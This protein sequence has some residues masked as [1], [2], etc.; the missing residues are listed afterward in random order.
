[1]EC[2]S[3]FS[4]KNNNKQIEMT[5]N[6]VIK[7]VENEREL[8]DAQ[9]VRRKVFQEEQEINTKL[10]FDGKDNEAEHIIVYSN[11]L[12]IGTAR[13]RYLDGTKKLAKIE[14]V[15]VI[16]EY[17][18]SGLGK[19]IMDYL[20]KYLEEKGVEEFKLESQEH[21]KGFY[22]KLGYKQNG[23][24]FEEVGIPHIEMRMR[25]RLK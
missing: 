5:E 8:K 19:K 4:D 21:A 23:D 18:G 13:A 3:G 22:E 6:F 16:K 15:A 2:S 17:R 11:I 14:R 20:H 9:E 1:M 12:P 10:D 25:K 24:A 7:I